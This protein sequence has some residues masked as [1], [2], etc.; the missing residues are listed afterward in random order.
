MKNVL[1]SVSDKTGIVEFAQEL[2]TLGAKIIS[3]GN[4]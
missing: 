1:I 4:V 2:S 3:T